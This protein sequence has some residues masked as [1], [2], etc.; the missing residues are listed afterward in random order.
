MATTKLYLDT[1]GK[2]ENEASPLKVCITSHGK[3]TYISLDVKLS[4]SQWDAEK[5]KVKNAPNGKLITSYINNKKVQIDNAILELSM[6]GE[7][8]GLTITQIKKKIQEHISPSVKND[9]LFI[10]RFRIF[11]ESRIAERTKEIYAT[12]LK[13]ILEYDKYAPSLSFEQITKEWLVGFDNYLKNQGL[14]KN[15]RNIHLR[16]IRAV[17]NDAIDNE[18]TSHYPMRK[19]NISPEETTKRSLTIEELRCL[20]SHKVE[21]WQERY[22]DYFKLTFY[23]I[24]INPVDL[25]ACTDGDVI[26]G[27]LVYKRHKTG[28]MYSIKIESEAMEIISKYKGVNQL[29]NFTE[30]MTT[31]KTFVGKANKAYKKIGDVVKIK[32]DEKTKHN[33][34]FSYHI[35]YKPFFPSLSIYWARHTWAT[36]AFSIGIPEEIIAE[37]LGH[38]HGNRTTAIYIDKSV[39][40]IDAAN[41][42]VID[43][44]LYN[45][46]VD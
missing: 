17:F 43:Y 6:R 4:K 24:G 19:F 41:R 11:G 8:T 13:K 37:A 42:K 3:S 33:R 10:T 45:K 22:L 1:R 20:F 23:L 36:I 32:N 39:A 40:N 35:K 15:S 2:K 34:K 46:E 16:N 12:T 30:K 44:V 18:I 27:R 29:V 25:C 9:D 28:R 14:V 31:Y 21:K 38:S 5:Q 7:L 26:N